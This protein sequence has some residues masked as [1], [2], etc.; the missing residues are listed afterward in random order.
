MAPPAASPPLPPPA[1][2]R[3]SFKMSTFVTC[4]AA[5]DVQWR[6]TRGPVKCSGETPTSTP[7]LSAAASFLPS[8]S[9]PCASRKSSDWSTTYAS[10]SAAAKY[11][12]RGSRKDINS[13]TSVE[14]LAS[15]Q[16]MM[17][18]P[19]LRKAPDVF[20]YVMMV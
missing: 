2:A 15:I 18:R 1:T 13:N 3:L 4:L 19:P 9:L 11:A 6:Y 7:L 12:S 17:G 8:C 16:R 14:V 10:P 20:L 5:V